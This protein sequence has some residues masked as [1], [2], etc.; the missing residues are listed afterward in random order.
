[1]TKYKKVCVLELMKTW[2]NDREL[3]ILSLRLESVMQAF[4]EKNK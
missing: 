4:S 3:L 1:M 2:I